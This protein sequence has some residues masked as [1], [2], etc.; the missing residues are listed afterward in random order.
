MNLQRFTRLTLLAAAFLLAA[1][2]SLDHFTDP[3]KEGKKI[4]IDCGELDLSEDAPP[5]VYQV[6]DTTCTRVPQ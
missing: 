1:C 5:A 2:E 6:S 3:P 4:V